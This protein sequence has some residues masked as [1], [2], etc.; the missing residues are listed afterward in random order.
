M[1]TIFA[2][3][4]GI[5]L[6]IIL[7]WAI[8]K[9]LLAHTTLHR[10]NRMV[11]LSIYAT[12]LLI[13]PLLQSIPSLALSETNAIISVSDI[14]ATIAHEQQ[15]DKSAG[16][17]LLPILLDIYVVGAIAL[18]LKLIIALLRT[19]FLLKKSR[20]IKV[21]G[22]NLVLHHHKG[23]VPFSWCRWIVM[24]QRDYNE[25]GDLII[26]HESAHLRKRH[27][28]D[29]IIAELVI[30]L[31]W[32]NPVAWFMRSALQDI[33]EYEADESVLKSGNVNFETYQL[34]LIKKTVGTRFAA[35]A[36]SLNHSSLK[37]RI[38]MM[39]SK[40]SQSKA[41][42][43]ALALVPATALALVFV[44]NSAIASTL[45]S[46]ASTEA[47]A[48]M[49]DKD[50]EKS[51][52]NA[53]QQSPDNEKGDVIKAPDEMPQFPGGMK[54]LME[55]ISQNIRY[56]EEAIKANKEGTVIVQFVITKTGEIKET[57]VARSQGE[58]LDA[59]AVRVVNSLPNFIPG[60]VD[61]KP[62]NVMYTIPIKFK[63]SANNNK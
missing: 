56:P 17:T 51:S 7:M 9:T 45:S 43:R 8:Y 63:M 46:V 21:N 14:T 48:N 54:A 10:F 49:S 55:Y 24:S 15:T 32:F 3:S 13:I 28:I 40:K 16:I 60:K 44:N 53:A 27:W 36:N 57:K 33:H 41:R 19:L 29:L 4:I 23:I 58:S 59:E 1:G 62:V 2:Y 47:V 18:L 31:N 5:S 37:K 42:M 30:I 6:P 50:S 35:I 25:Q 11:L 12:A 20:H 61:G 22:Y 52:V 38:T 34:F 26:A 39:L